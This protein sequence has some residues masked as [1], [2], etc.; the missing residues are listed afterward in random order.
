MNSDRLAAA[1]AGLVDPA[2]GAGLVT[3]FVAI[4][5]DLA[6]RTLARTST[7]KFVEIFVQCM[8]KLSSGTYESHPKVDEYL[9]RKIENETAI[10]ESLRIVGARIARS[11]YSIRNKRNVAH[12]GEIDPNST[13]LGYCY[14]G[15][16]WIMSE[17]L[18][19]AQGISVEEAS[20]LIALV[21]APVGSLVE[22]ID[23]T[24]VVLVDVPIRAELLILMH[25]QYP[26]LLTVAEALKSLSRRS[27][28]SVRNK[29]RELHND[30]L[31]QGSA[32]DGY[33]LT[34]TGFTAALVEVR[35][36]L[37]LQ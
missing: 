27:P 13:D 9:A 8:Q 30:K 25:S 5:H 22:E 11:I 29:L 34:Q 18:R 16:C 12:I 1:L 36:R 3:Q 4:R 15:A 7:G 37:P 2:L 19:L 23:G 32:K 24:S 31:A 10:A 14:A 26:A 35:S 28:A 20:S 21:N 17:M 33:K 6:T